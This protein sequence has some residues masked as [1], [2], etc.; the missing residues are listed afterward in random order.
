MSKRLGEVMTEITAQFFH[1]T[2]TWGSILDQFAGFIGSSFRTLFNSLATELARNLIAQNTWLTQTLA[3]VATAVTAYLSQAFAALT[4]FFWWAGP[5]APVLA[6]GVIAAAI[7]AIAALGGQIVRAIFPSVGGSTTP[8]QTD[9][10]D[11]DRSRSPGRQVMEITGPTRDLLTTLLSPLARLDEQTGILVR[12]HDL[13][14]A[15]LPMMR[16]LALAG[17]GG[18]TVNVYAGL[19]ADGRQIGEDVLDVLEEALADRLTYDR[20]GESR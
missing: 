16:D 9:I 17:P 8:P 7:A 10:G 20:R 15:R 19:G 12:I 5:A 2:A 4:A 13:L 3:N 11:G 1:G 18:I 6:G 14:D